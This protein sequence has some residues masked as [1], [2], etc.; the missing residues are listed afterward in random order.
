MKKL[1]LMLAF[2]FSVATVNSFAADKDKGKKEKCKAGKECCKDMKNM[3][4]AAKAKC[5]KKCADE[6]KKK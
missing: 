3:S 5:A 6:A 2:V 4:A 1:T